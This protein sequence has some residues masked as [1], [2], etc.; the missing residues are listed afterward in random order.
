MTDNPERRPDVPPTGGEGRSRGYV[1]GLYRLLR[2]S[3][4]E[5]ER[6]AR[7]QAESGDE[8]ARADYEQQ[9]RWRARVAAQPRKTP[10][11]T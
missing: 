5:A 8:E 4:R 7:E 6:K 1:V 2:R 3:A 9:A 11:S 10:G